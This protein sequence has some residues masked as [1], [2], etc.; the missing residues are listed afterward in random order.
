MMI[1]F[2]SSAAYN[3][4]IKK[5]KCFGPTHSLY[6]RAMPYGLPRHAALPVFN[7]AV[8]AVRIREVAQYKRAQTCQLSSGSFTRRKKGAKTDNKH[9]ARCRCA[10]IKSKL[11]AE[12]TERA[13]PT[14]IVVGLTAPIPT[15]RLTRHVNLPFVATTGLC[16]SSSSATMNC[17][18]DTER[19]N[20]QEGTHKNIIQGVIV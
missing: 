13:T 14:E 17:L 4:T 12:N 9:A 2:C 11:R 16:S 10:S 7:F 18:T 3:L 6:S 19:A 1:V 8:L 5:K 20:R 15:Q